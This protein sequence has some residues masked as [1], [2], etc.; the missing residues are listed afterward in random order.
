MK[1]NLL[2]LAALT[3]SITSIAQNNDTAQ[4]T[5]S[6]V[7]FYIGPG[8]GAN[9][10][11]GIIGAVVEI[12]IN[13]RISGFGGV[14]LGSWGYKAGFG[15]KAYLNKGQFGSSF[16]LGYTNA[17]GL[18]DLEIEMELADGSS[19]DVTMD[20]YNAGSINFTYD[21]NFHLGK[22]SKFVLGLGYALPVATAPYT[23]THPRNVE[24][25]RTSKQAMHVIQP[26]GLV[27]SLTFLI[28][29][30]R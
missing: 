11:T 26:G 9:A 27:L 15:V 3:I 17:F 21:Y 10:Y 12:P 2:L 23:V 29:A 6:K 18:S 22:R 30:G 28:A 24:L 14:G 8:T 1:L 7:P 20:L 5:Q 16:S 25:S 19:T 4:P 13:Q